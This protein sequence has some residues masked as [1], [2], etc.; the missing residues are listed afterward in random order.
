MT[1]KEF[2][3]I[4]KL[5]GLKKPDW[6]YRLGYQGSKNTMFLNCDRYE[7]GLRPIPLYLAQ[8][9]WLLNAIAQGNLTVGPDGLPEFPSWPAYEREPIV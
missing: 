9:V 2:R 4:R 7:S 3:D 8:Y 5:F 1:G 6:M